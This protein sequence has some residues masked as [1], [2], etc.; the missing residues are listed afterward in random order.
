MGS[1]QRLEVGTGQGK[2]VPKDGQQEDACG[3]GTVYCLHDGYQNIHGDEAVKNFT[4]TETQW[5]PVKLG[6]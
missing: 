6:D 4:H 1:F 5:V 3:L 2:G